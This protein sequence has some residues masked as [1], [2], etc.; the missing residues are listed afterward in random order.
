MKSKRNDGERLK[1][2][3]RDSRESTAPFL[4]HGQVQALEEVNKDEH[5]RDES[6]NCGG[7]SR[8]IRRTNGALCTGP[9]LTPRP[10]Q[11][12]KTTRLYRYTERI[13]MILMSPW[14]SQKFDL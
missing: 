4:D 1:E 10:R 14:N 5:K 9:L 12:R 11:G 6:R 3:D 13:L 8:E 7:R 2:K